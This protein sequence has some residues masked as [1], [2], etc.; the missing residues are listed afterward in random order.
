MAGGIESPGVERA[1]Q[2]RQMR[3]IGLAL[4]DQL[5]AAVGAHV[6]ER[7]NLAV[8]AAYNQQRGTSGIEHQH[9]AGI[10]NIARQSRYDRFA[11]KQLLALGG[12]ADFVSIDTFGQRHRASRQIGRFCG[13]QL[14][15]A[16]LRLAR[17]LLALRSETGGQSGIAVA[18]CLTKLPVYARRYDA[19]VGIRSKL[20]HSIGVRTKW[21]SIRSAR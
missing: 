3:R 14:D 20:A 4:F 5:R 1:D 2:P 18:H 10:W 15:H 16:A 17:H 6:A 9:I 7:A 8:L 12:E 19:T 11:Q 13:D 21:A